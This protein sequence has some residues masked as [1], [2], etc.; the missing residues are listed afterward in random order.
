VVT[1]TSSSTSCTSLVCEPSDGDGIGD[2]EGITSSLRR[3]VVSAI[4]AIWI[5]PSSPVAVRDALT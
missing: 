5:L 1:G 3:L 4:N 2:F